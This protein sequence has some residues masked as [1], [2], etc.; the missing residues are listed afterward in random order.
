MRQE[1]NDILVKLG[2]K[3]I[4]LIENENEEG[5]TEEEFKERNSILKEFY[6]NHHRFITKFEQSESPTERKKMIQERQEIIRT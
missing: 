4:E 3:L 1:Q 2:G 6:K 5:E